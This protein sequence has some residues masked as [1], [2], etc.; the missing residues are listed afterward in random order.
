MDGRM[1]IAGWLTGVALVALSMAPLAEA[2]S[3]STV[4]GTVSD[5]SGARLAGVRVELLRA[6]H[7][8]VA[9]ATDARGA[10][11]FDAEGTGDV[12]FSKAGFATATRAVARDAATLDV[13]LEVG[14]FADE[15][16][17]TAT[18]TEAALSAVTERVSVLTSRELV[19]LGARSLADA[20]RTV[21]GLV[22]ESTG[23]EGALASVFTRGGESDYNL[24][25]LDGVRVNQVGGYYDFSR[26][27]AEEV[28][29]VEVVRGAQSALYGSDAIGAVVQVFTKRAGASDPLR[30]AG[31]VEGGSFG[32]FQGSARVMTGLAQRGDLSLGATHRR[33]NGAFDDI[34]PEEDRFEQT[35]LSLRGGVVLTPNASLRGSVRYNEAEGRSV[36]QISYSV[37]DR[38]TSYNTRDLSFDVSF[39]Q[40]LA[41]WFSHAASVSYFDYEGLSADSFADPTVNVYAVLS[42]TIG[43]I[44]PDSP[45][46]ERLIT[47]S[48]FEAIRGGAQALPAGQFAAFTAFGVSDFAPS[49]SRT[50]FTRPSVRYQADLA[51]A[52]GQVLSAG[53]DY[54]KEQDSLTD[55]FERS[56]SAFFF[57]QQFSAGRRLFGGV[58]GRVDDNS[59]YGTEFSPKV[60]AGAFLLPYT[61]GAVSSAK[62]QFNYGQG[63]KNPTFGELFGSAFSDGNPDLKPER[64]RVWDVGAE[65]TLADQRLLVGMAYFKA[66]YEDQVAF[67]STGFGLD[68]RPDFVNI[69]GSEASGA[70]FELRLQR[71]VAGITASLN[72]TYTDTEVTATTSTSQQFQPGQPLLRRPKHAVNMSATWQREALRVSMNLRRIGERHDS[73]FLFLTTQALPG[74]PSGRSTDITVNPAYTLVGL[75]AEYQV[76]RDVGIYVRADNLLDEEYDSAL[77]FPGLPRAFA[78]GVRF[79]FPAR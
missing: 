20:V 6:G 50:Q 23:R 45:R 3:S 11:S 4:R 56:N 37:F 2:Q 10:Y 43:A 70:E 47:R 18:R 8:V 67:R 78:V 69:A 55:R 60:S 46:L 74:F 34:L 79:L 7:V 66:D 44:F 59:F 22:V 33:T 68:G 5:T 77:G 73:S 1:R 27:N 48:E 57:Q 14:A 65:V 72:Y 32:S 24:V 52:P 28:E 75:N 26:I 19:Q 36:G 16:V 58:G 49:T 42:G 71:P 76:L 40:R 63:I 13:V 21:P 12:V 9:T 39:E 30:V 62:A 38:G 41:P 31:S 53:Y 25:L 17:V 15:T 35:A 61:A 64:A 51:W 29:R 54:E